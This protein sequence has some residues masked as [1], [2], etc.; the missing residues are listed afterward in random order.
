MPLL[1]SNKQL[2]SPDCLAIFDPDRE[3]TLTTDACDYAM[4]A[5]LTQQYEYGE[6]PIAFVSKSLVD[7]ELKYN[8]WEKELFAVV[9]ATKYFR[10]YLL[11][12]KFTIRSDNKPSTQLITN[13]SFKLT[14]SATSRVIHWILA[15]Q[16]YH[17]EIQHHPGKS[18][19]VADALSRFPL[20]KA[21]KCNTTISQP[22]HPLSQQLTALYQSHPSTSLLWDTLQLATTHPRYQ[23]IHVL[24]YTREPFPRILLPNDASFRADLLKELHDTPLAGH[25]G[26]HKLLNYVN[27][28]YTGLHIRQDVL[29]FTRSCPECQKSKPRHERPQGITKPL[30]PPQTSW[31]H[32]SMDLITQLP[33]S[34]A[35]D[36]IFIIVD[37]FSKMAHFIPTNTT[38]DANTLAHLFLDNIAR[39][40]GFPR[41]IVSDR[42][43]RFLSAFWHEL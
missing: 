16:P 38:A 19:V 28:R 3:T 12:R 14:T 8:L 43:S 17:F 6:R 30:E 40:H 18:N 24:I 10:P 25:P 23:I 11:H 41:S 37:R 39:L 4:G 21:S 22:I 35:Y 2:H 33:H 7:S 36:A 42:D 32:I 34:N 27:Q 1:N 20:Q 5:V 13:P 15:I 29:D 9:W 26:F 31:R